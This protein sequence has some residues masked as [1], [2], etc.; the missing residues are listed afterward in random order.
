[1]IIVSIN[2]CFFKFLC[3]AATQLAHQ[4]QQERTQKNVLGREF[5]QCLMLH[6]RPCLLLCFIY[7]I[8][9]NHYG[10]GVSSCQQTSDNNLGWPDPHPAP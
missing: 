4:L 9:G 8:L 3:F 2:V 1:M 6:L 5:L 10:P 7:P